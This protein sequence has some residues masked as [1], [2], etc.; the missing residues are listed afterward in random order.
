MSERLTF[1]LRYHD[2]AA[3]PIPS[4]EVSGTREQIISVLRWSTDE[5][6]FGP[7]LN[8][9]RVDGMS[10]SGVLDIMSELIDMVSNTEHPPGMN[11]IVI[12]IV[13]NGADR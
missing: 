6:P 2:S 4:A 5:Q 1:T 7:F 13:L 12:R 11:D 8:R 9:M 3:N 10:V